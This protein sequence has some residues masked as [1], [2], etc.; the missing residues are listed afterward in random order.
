MFQR[1]TMKNN[2]KYLAVLGLLFIVITTTVAQ[3]KSRKDLERVFNGESIFQYEAA[4][5]IALGYAEEKNRK[6]AEEWLKKIPAGTNASERATQLLK[7]L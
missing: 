2:I 5:Y 4:F 7:K 3:K 6:M 1:N